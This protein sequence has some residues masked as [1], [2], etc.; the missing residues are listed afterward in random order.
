MLSLY[1]VR[2]LSCMHLKMMFL[3]QDIHPKMREITLLC[4]YVVQIHNIAPSDHP[5]CH[6]LC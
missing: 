1:G 3:L 6:C 4:L 2:V 5:V